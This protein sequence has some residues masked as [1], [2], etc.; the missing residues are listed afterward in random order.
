MDKQQM[1]RLLGAFVGV[2][3]VVSMFA[4]ALLSGGNDNSGSDVVIDD[5]LQPS[6]FTYSVSFDSEVMKE[7]SSLKFYGYTSEVNIQD[8]DRVIIAIDGVR[9]VRS[10]FTV[11]GGDE[12]GYV[13]EITTKKDYSLV[14]IANQINSLEYFSFTESAKYVTIASPTE[15]VLLVNDVLG[16]DKNYLFEEGTLSAIVAVDTLPGHEI[17]VNGEVKLQ[18]NTI[19]SLE[20]YEYLNYSTAIDQNSE[21]SIDD[22]NVPNEEFEISDD[23]LESPLEDG[24]EVVVEESDFE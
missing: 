15:E 24:F 11:T 23:E 19:V 1:L 7:L 16:L 17:Y 9:S 10:S 20:L 13:A 8:I 5:S 4:V 6:V 3:M 2:V 12:W 22:L 21:I 18:G 14:E